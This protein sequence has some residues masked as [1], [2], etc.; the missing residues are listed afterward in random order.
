M[1][2]PVKVAAGARR[3]F[4]LIELLLAV[5]LLV[6]IVLVSG[7]IFDTTVR[8]VSQSQAT[9]EL[10]ASLEAFAQL[11]RKDI[12]AIEHDGFL[13][14][15]ARCQEAFGTASDRA[16]GRRQTFRNDWIEFFTNAEQDASIDA[17]TIGQWSRTLYGH[18]RVSDRAGYAFKDQTRSMPLTPGMHAAYSNLG[19]DWVVMRHQ[20]HVMA[21]SRLPERQLENLE[22]ADG[23][24]QY[25]TGTMYNRSLLSYVVRDFRWSCWYNC[26]WVGSVQVQYGVD[27]QTGTGR[28]AIY[29]PLYYH[30]M[31]TYSMTDRRGF[32][33]LPHCPHFEV[34]YAMAED[35][36]ACPAGTV[37]WRDPP[38]LGQSG[39]ADPNY[40]PAVRIDPLHL[41]ATLPANDG[42]HAGRLPFG[43]GDRWP[44]LLKITVHVFDPLDRLAGGK[45]MS[46]VTVV[47]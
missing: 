31:P 19:T 21:K 25:S 47:P 12:R 29:E 26:Q 6:L 13:V 15:G 28:L 1:S 5:T 23:T 46:V 40:N 20:L 17:R 9:S 42:E 39:Y 2:G 11:L 3:A 45:K 43:P 10:N 35:L 41:K 37:R 44:V 32:H 33:A 14:I 36:Q 27:G 22:V 30:Y 8:A 24:W 18:G 38:M 7:Y 4:T 34:H 16:N